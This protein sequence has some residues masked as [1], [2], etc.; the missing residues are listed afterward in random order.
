MK[1]N[2]K[3]MIIVNDNDYN[4]RY[5]ESNV[6]KTKIK[7]W[8]TKIKLLLTCVVIKTTIKIIKILV[9]TIVIMTVIIIIND[10]NL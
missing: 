3:H 4:N 5:D 9:T 2:G 7:K 1:F 6:N 8:I 10:N